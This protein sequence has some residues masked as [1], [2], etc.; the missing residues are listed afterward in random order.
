M[1]IA[2]VVVVCLAAILG[3]G[4]QKVVIEYSD[5]LTEPATVVDLVF[6]PS[7]HGS[8][9]GP[10]IDLTGEGGIGIAI[11]SVSIPERYAVVFQCPHGKFIIQSEKAKEL[12]KRLKVGQEVTVTY[13]EKYRTTYED[14][15][16]VSRILVKYDFLDAR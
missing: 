16:V 6:S 5:V 12:W 4:C 10:T 9:V 7:R 15:K 8:G 11:T 14:E 13:K 2:R 1:R 3:A